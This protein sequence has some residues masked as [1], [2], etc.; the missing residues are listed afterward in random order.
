MTYT[1]GTWAASTITIPMVASRI[2]RDWCVCN[3]LV[4]QCIWMATLKCIGHAIT[5]RTMG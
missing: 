1:D 4:Y 2:G 3:L 5:R